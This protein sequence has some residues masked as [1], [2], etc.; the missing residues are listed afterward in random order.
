MRLGCGHIGVPQNL[1]DD[2]GRHAKAIEICTETSAKTMPSFP[3]AF[4][5]GAEHAT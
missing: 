5:L 1:L 2:F 4:E 3:S